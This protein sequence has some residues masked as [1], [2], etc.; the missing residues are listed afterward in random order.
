MVIPVSD[1]DTHSAGQP[2]P[3]RV[4]YLVQWQRRPGCAAMD[5]WE[6]MVYR[7]DLESADFAAQTLANADRPSR[8]VKRVISSEVVAIF[9]VEG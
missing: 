9:R 5:A 7:A 8:I 3:E 6:D 4:E 2:L 1:F